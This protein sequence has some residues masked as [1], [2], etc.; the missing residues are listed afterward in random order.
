MFDLHNHLLPGI[1]DGAKDWDMAL[2][3]A[4]MAS[5]DGTQALVFTPHNSAWWSGYYQE[6]V[7]RLTREFQQ[8]LSDAGVPLQVGAGAEIYFELD[9]LKRLK[10]GR[11]A[12]LN[13]SRYLLI[14]LP[15][16]SWPLST[17]HVFFELQVAG[18]TPIMAHPERNAIVM[19][20]PHL[21]GV[22]AERG[23]LGQI[24]SGS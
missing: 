9:L 14:E 16:T 1:D 6:K 5:A 2:A 3:M 17:E 12:P 15:F 7:E 20:K 10:D 22:L 24:T 8:R 18:Y 4:R 23:V 11:A 21:M 13:G 19:E